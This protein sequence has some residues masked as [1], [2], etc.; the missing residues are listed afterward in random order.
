MSFCQNNAGHLLR[1]YSAG[2]CPSTLHCNDGC[3]T[4]MV[5]DREYLYRG[6]HIIIN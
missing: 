6:L 5:L 3:L 2:T 1:K 4:L